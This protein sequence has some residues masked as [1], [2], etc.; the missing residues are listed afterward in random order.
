MHTARGAFTLIELLVVISIVALLIALLLPALQQARDEVKRVSCMNQLR[1]LALATF[2]Y[3][4]DSD[5]LFPYNYYFTAA[6]GYPGGAG[7]GQLVFDYLSGGL[8]TFVCPSDR[9]HTDPTH[10]WYQP[11]GSAGPIGRFGDPRMSYNY[12][13]RLFGETYSFTPGYPIPLTPSIRI[14]AVNSPS[15]CYMWLDTTADW[16]GIDFHDIPYDT[17]GGYGWESIHQG[18]DS[19]VFV[20]GHAESIDTRDLPFYDLIGP[21]EYRGYT[22]DPDY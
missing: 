10:P 3:A 7:P 16:S 21:T 15:K 9:I 6:P 13:K 1:Q 8:V 11:P 2:M 19:F 14:E 5:D 17:F 4:G 18:F 20:D 12:A 22:N